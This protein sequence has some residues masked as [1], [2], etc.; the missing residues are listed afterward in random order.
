L[1]RV[2]VTLRHVGLIEA[3]PTFRSDDLEVDIA[4]KKVFVAAKEV[5]LTVTEYA[6]LARLVRDHGRVVSQTQL[7]R[8]VWGSIAESETHYLRIYINQLRKKLEIDPSNPRHILTES[9]VGYR[10]I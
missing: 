6:V 4:Q 8:Q 3:T 10:L 5:K 2:R 9:G 1:A 7:M